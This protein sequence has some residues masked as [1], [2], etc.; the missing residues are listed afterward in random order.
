VSILRRDRIIVFQCDECGDDCE[1]GHD[2]F[3]KALE[4]VK[5]LGWIAKL[6]AGEWTHLCPVCKE[7]K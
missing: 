7:R 2:E 5:G 3:L 4:F 6:F 1:T